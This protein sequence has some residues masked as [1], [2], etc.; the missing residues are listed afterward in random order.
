MSELK[1]LY[2]DKRLCVCLKPAGVL[3]TDEPGGLPELAR[4]ALGGEIFTVHRLDRVVGGVMV[5]ARTRETASE[6]SRQIRSGGFGKRYLAAVL[7]APE[8]KCGELR[9]LLMRDR[10][11]RMT[12]VVTEPQRCAQEAVLRY[13]LL[14]EASGM[15][16]LRIELGTGRTHQIRA[17]LSSRGMPIAGD[18][19]YGG[20]VCECPTALWSCAVSFTHPRTGRRM[21]FSAPPERRFPWDAFD[22]SLF[23]PDFLEIK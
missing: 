10:A 9:D 12:V 4:A 8:A 7:G 20:G 3:Y 15:S 18:R 11:R 22:E 1:F 16:L 5:L 21:C 6:L 17:Q 13:E 2:R 23:L 19:K 14:G